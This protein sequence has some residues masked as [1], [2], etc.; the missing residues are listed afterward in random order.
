MLYNLSEKFV[1]F[2]PHRLFVGIYLK[3]LKNIFFIINDADRDK[4]FDFR[5]HPVDH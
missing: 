4:N 5:S 2:L 3:F 1:Q